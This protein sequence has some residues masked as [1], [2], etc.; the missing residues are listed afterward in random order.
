L[1]LAIAPDVKP[2]P[3]CGTTIL[4]TQTGVIFIHRGIDWLE[5]DPHTGKFELHDIQV[6]A[7]SK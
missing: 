2:P 1:C 3:G 6:T 7:N 5:E 4:D